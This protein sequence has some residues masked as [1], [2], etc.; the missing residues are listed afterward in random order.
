MHGRAGQKE[1]VSLVNKRVYVGY[2]S[3]LFY[4]MRA[5]NEAV[6]HA[7]RRR[8]ASLTNSVFHA[9][10]LRQIPLE[11]AGIGAPPYHLLVFDS[12]QRCI[13]KGFRFH[14]CSLPYPP[15]SFIDLGAGVF[16]AM[17]ELC[18]LQM[19]RS[20]SLPQLI[21]LGCMLCS[22]YA[23]DDEGNATLRKSP[24]TTKKQLAAYLDK[25]GSMKGTGKARRALDNVREHALS[26]RETRLLS[27][28]CLSRHFGGYGIPLPDASTPLISHTW[29]NRLLGS[30]ELPFALVWLTQG[31]ELAVFDARPDRIPPRGEDGIFTGTRGLV[32]SSANVTLSFHVF[33]MSFSTME[34][35]EDFDECARQ[36][37]RIFNKH[38]RP[39]TVKQFRN[40]ADL[41]TVL[42]R[43]DDGKAAFADVIARG[44]MSPVKKRSPDK[45]Y[46]V[47]T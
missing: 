4:W 42:A 14:V 13:K 30:P 12:D 3:A 32:F 28:L 44:H 45:T 43:G 23:F 47:T 16:V 46:V 11:K 36:L 15:G 40:I 33:E 21:E 18:F 19:A 10:T 41:R 29:A 38:S 25:A 20:L 22:L 1:E 24:L 7:R 2:D 27:L 31:V 17:P 26:P 9:M 8:A 6:L 35:V 39:T 5:E 37:L 34:S